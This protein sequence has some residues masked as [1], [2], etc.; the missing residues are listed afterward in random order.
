MYFATVSNW[1][2]ALK[3]YECGFISFDPEITDVLNEGQEAELIF[4]GS[5][6][7][8]G[9]NEV[10]LKSLLRDLRKPYQY[11]ADAI[12]YDWVN[13]RWYALPDPEEEV[14]KILP[15]WIDK[16]VENG[17]GQQLKKLNILVR[18]AIARLNYE[19]TESYSNKYI[20]FAKLGRYEWVKFD[21]KDFLLRL[22]LLGL[23]ENSFSL[24][25]SPERSDDCYAIWTFRYDKEEKIVSLD[26]TERVN[27]GYGWDTSESLELTFDEEGKFVSGDHYYGFAGEYKNLS[28]SEDIE[29]SFNKWID[30]GGLEKP[31]SIDIE[32]VFE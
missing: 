4:V 27:S 1:F 15:N 7:M 12:Y 16:L 11:Y 17:D 23:L 13:Q 2:T 30:L 5:L 18:E 6:V 32:N 3:L 22:D 21:Y 28:C 19:E 10:M 20:K 31:T 9:C 14:V 24:S 25:F 8:A 29:R 26:M